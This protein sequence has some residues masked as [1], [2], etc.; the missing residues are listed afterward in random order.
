[1]R[2]YWYTHTFTDTHIFGTVC[3]QKVKLSLEISGTTH[4]Y[5]MPRDTTHPL[6]GWS[7]HCGLRNRLWRAQV[8]VLWWFEATTDVEM[9]WHKAWIW[10]FHGIPGTSTVFQN[11][12]IYKFAHFPHLHFFPKG[13]HAAS[14]VPGSAPGQQPLR[15][16][17]GRSDHPNAGARWA[18]VHNLVAEN[19]KP[20]PSNFC[21]TIYI[22]YLFVYLY[23]IVVTCCYCTHNCHVIYFLVS[24]C[25][26]RFCSAVL[27]QVR[28]QPDNSLLVSI[29]TCLHTGWNLC[30]GQ[31]FVANLIFLATRLERC[32]ETWG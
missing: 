21:C 19:P 5:S 32:H 22:Y 1:M 13:T 18:T 6:R 17:C 3:C 28:V 10:G 25:H 8:P 7:L 26:L 16:H 11:L 14:Q 9:L 31:V 15:L 24:W 27:P 4:G 12:F 20:S 23:T 30:F 29:E 2:Y